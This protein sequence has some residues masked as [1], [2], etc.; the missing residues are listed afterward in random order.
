VHKTQNIQSSN[1]G[2]CSFSLS[3]DSVRGC[4][5]MYWRH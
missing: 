1:I 3:V 5:R 2:F 4:E